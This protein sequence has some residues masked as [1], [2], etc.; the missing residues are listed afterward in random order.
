M[1]DTELLLEVE[2]TDLLHC[3]LFIGKKILFALHFTVFWQ[4]DKRGELVFDNLKKFIFEFGTLIR[5]FFRVLVEVVVTIGLFPKAFVHDVDIVFVLPVT[6]CWGVCEQA[7]SYLYFKDAGWG[8]LVKRACYIFTNWVF[9]TN[10]WFLNKVSVEHA[11]YINFTIFCL[12]LKML[13][14]SFSFSTL[15]LKLN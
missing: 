14:S 13:Q 6:I 5:F 3:M 2:W 10:I 7:A 9:K 12:S 11:F 15:V 4:L 1:S 8:I